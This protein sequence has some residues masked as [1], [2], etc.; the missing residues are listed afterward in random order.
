MATGLSTNS[1]CH[2][3]L[4]HLFSTFLVLS[5]P[6]AFWMNPHPG[7]VAPSFILA[8]IILLFNPFMV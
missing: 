1:E 3:Q 8:V 2:K 6:D 4:A 7:L 5:L